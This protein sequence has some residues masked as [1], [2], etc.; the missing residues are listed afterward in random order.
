[1]GKAKAVIY[2]LQGTLIDVSFIRERFL[3]GEKKDFAG[4]HQAT[5]N[6]PPNWTV[7]KNCHRDMREGRIILP[8]TGMNEAFRPVAQD[9]LDTHMVRSP[10]LWMRPD[11][12]FRKDF[13][14]KGEHLKELREIYDVV[15]A[16]DDNPQM[17]EFW[18]DQGISY[19]EVP[20]WQEFVSG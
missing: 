2:D 13:I 19:T 9:W 4:F 17:I 5:G 8:L 10:G 18:R 14:V 15:H 11:G 16:Y 6:C 12:D 3:G 7:L 20:G 1:M